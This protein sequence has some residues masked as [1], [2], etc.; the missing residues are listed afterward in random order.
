VRFRR[1]LRP[2]A[3]LSLG[4]S[5]LGEGVARGGAWVRE[6]GVATHAAAWPAAGAAPA[7]AVGV[8]APTPA[9]SAVLVGHWCG[10][11][12]RGCVRVRRQ[13]LGQRTHRGCDV[14]DVCLAL[15]G[16]SLQSNLTCPPV[17]GSEESRNHA[18]DQE[19]RALTKATRGVLQP[20]RWP[21]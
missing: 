9:W 12:P 4:R 1:R 20:Y 15:H 11:E 8:G 3:L 5:V 7:G 21:G 10:A 18:R 16:L 13:R 14:V 2:S 17:M 19:A 6:E